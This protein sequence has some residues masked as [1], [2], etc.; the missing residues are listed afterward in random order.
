M[1][2]PS[3]PSPYP[4]RCPSAQFDLRSHLKTVWNC[5]LLAEVRIVELPCDNVMQLTLH[6]LLVNLTSYPFVLF[7]TQ[8]MPLFVPPRYNDFPT[9][10]LANSRLFTQTPVPRHPSV[11]GHWLNFIPC[12]FLHNIVDVGLNLIGYG[13]LNARP[14]FNLHSLLISLNSSPSSSAT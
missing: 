13:A 11:L 9:S 10:D 8:W 1:W 4:H 2:L 5:I 12:I 14:S 6:F 7:T 3:L